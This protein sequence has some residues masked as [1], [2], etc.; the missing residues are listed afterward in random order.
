MLEMRLRVYVL[1]LAVVD[2]MLIDVFSDLGCACVLGCAC[3]D[4]THQ[5]SRQVYVDGL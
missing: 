4:C 2:E 1:L 5:V 3:H